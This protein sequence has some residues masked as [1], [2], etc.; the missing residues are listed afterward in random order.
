MEPT[1]LERP[2]LGYLLPTREAITDGITTARLLGLADLATAAG[3]DS[4]WAGDSITAR[5]R[6]DPLTL[7][8]ALATTTVATIGT[9]VLLPVLRH[10]VPLA[11]QIATLDQVCEGRLVVGVGIANDTPAVRAEFANAGTEFERRVGRFN[12]HIH[13]MRRLWSESIVTHRG[14]FYELE[15]A[16]VRPR[17]AQDGG[18]PLWYAANSHAGYRRA[19]SRFEGVIPIGPLERCREGIALTSALA[20]ELERPAPPVAAAYLTVTLDEDSERAESKLD[21]FLDAY[22]PGHGPAMRTLQGCYA[23]PASSLAGILDTYAQS[24]IEHLVVRFAGDPE[25]QLT[26]F[27]TVAR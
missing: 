20:G 3:F 27:E 13:V 4:L 14:A 24:G 21:S 17:P 19:A 18:P 22:Y 16:S 9:A 11:H 1:Q 23:G 8:A 5:P 2:S 6:H 26:H 15:E 7:L 12:E 25:L 10:P